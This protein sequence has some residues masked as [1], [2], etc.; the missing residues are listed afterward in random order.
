MKKWI[1]AATVALAL[2]AFGGAALAQQTPQ[3]PTQQEQT[4]PA[5]EGCNYDQQ[6]TS[7]SEV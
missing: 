6:N 2:T 3:E 1:G 4:T 5:K 7:G